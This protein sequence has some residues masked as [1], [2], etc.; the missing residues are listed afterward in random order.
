MAKK[1]YTHAKGFNVT[2]I[3][4][5]S[6]IYFFLDSNGEI[7]YIGKCDGNYKNRINS[8]CCGDFGKLDDEIKYMY[9]V[10]ADLEKYPL[11]VLEQLFIRCF[12]TG[13]K[14]KQFQ[15]FYSYNEKVIKQIAKKKNLK[16]HGSIKKF[17]LKFESVLLER[18]Y[19]EDK[20]YKK[21]G[22]IETLKTKKIIC[23][24]TNNCMCFKCFV[25]KQSNSLLK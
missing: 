5:F 17:I 10:L 22:E 19:E 9:A 12:K 11:H 21:Y 14:N 25:E 16:I 1:E 18:E 8:H 24:D 6:G 3:N 20:K 23:D 7:K 13:P 15:L 4:G 2:S